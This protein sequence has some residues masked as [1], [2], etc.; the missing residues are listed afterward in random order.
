MN[1]YIFTD[2]LAA[3]GIGVVVA[4][5]AMCLVRT[6]HHVR[7]VCNVDGA[8]PSYEWNT[9]SPGILER[10]ITSGVSVVPI[11]ADQ[12]GNVL[13]TI[14]TRDGVVVHASW[15]G[16]LL[17]RARELQR[18]DLKLVYFMHSS[19]DEDVVKM[20]DELLEHLQGAY[21][22]VTASDI[23]ANDIR[24]VSNDVK[25]HRLTYGVDTD[26]FYPP[27]SARGERKRRQVLFIGRPN[28]VKGGHL[29][30]AIAKRLEQ[31]G[32]EVWVHG[33]FRKGDYG[34]ENVPNVFRTES[35]VSDAEVAELMRSSAALIVPSTRG[36]GQPLVV[37]EGIACGTVVVAAEGAAGGLW[38]EH[39]VVVVPPDAESVSN[40]VVNAFEDQ[41]AMQKRVQVG[42]RQVANFTWKIHVEQFTR[43]VGWNT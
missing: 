25:L 33:V 22:V 26:V 1:I 34:Y 27:A 2:H 11:A 31:S 18:P 30:S 23:V 39:P 6:G 13:Q 36:E 12:I 3:G 35:A 24:A 41:A 37:L 20:D 4:Q 40:A 42:V 21:L 32:I 9:M 28:R 5:H 19:C 16:R 14:Q 17:A 38:P 8:V 43:A 15:R 10:L 29:V 7:V